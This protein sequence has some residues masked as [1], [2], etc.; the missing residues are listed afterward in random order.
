M[1]WW[2]LMLQNG[3]TFIQA[4]F[5]FSVYFFSYVLEKLTSLEL[6]INK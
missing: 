5:D 2:Y 3:C 4:S 1:S 6:N